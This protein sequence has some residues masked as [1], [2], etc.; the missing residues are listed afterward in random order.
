[1]LVFLSPSN[2]SQN[3][4]NNKAT[5]SYTSS[6]HQ[7]CALNTVP[8][9]YPKP[10]I[11]QSWNYTIKYQ[12]IHLQY[13]PTIVR[14][15]KFMLSLTHMLS[16][17]IFQKKYVNFIPMTFDYVIS[18]ND[19]ANFIKHNFWHYMVQ[20]IGDHTNNF[21]QI[22]FLINGP[23]KLKLRNTIPINTLT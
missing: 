5:Q 22:L 15:S 4:F 10:H 14:Q 9:S 19:M 13:I 8:T 23:H 17:A 21:N 12:F 7:F 20:F 2:R 3:K 1:M 18:S 11:C 6:K 16:L